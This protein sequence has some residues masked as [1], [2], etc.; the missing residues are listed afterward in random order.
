VSE[1]Y[2]S[3]FEDS[4]K[5]PLTKRQKKLFDE[6]LI[7]NEIIEKGFWSDTYTILDEEYILKL[8]ENKFK[9]FETKYKKML[10]PNSLKLF[11]NIK[12]KREKNKIC[13]QGFS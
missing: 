11:K 5:I 6:E 7:D 10:E 4:S 9:Y 1:N 13:T 12:Y 3:S 8:P 2:Y